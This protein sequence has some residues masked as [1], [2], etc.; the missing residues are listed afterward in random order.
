MRE[1]PRLSS[2]LANLGPDD[3]IITCTIA[4]GEVQ[5]G[6]ERLAEGQRRAILESKAEK[7]FASLPCEPVPAAAGDRYAV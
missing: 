3:R 6:L 1:D 7:V 5:F 2:W 4:R